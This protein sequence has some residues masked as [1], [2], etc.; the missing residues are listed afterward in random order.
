[1]SAAGEQRAGVDRLDLVEIRVGAR[2]QA[3]PGRAAVGRAEQRPEVAGRVALRA[4]ERHRADR[5]ALR[6]RVAPLPAGRSDL[7]VC[8]RSRPRRPPPRQL[9]PPPPPPPPARASR[10]PPPPRRPRS[11]LP[12]RRCKRQ[13]TNPPVR[14]GAAHGGGGALRGASHDKRKSTRQKPNHFS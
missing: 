2:K 4:R 7:Y 14:R 5:V 12:P 3:G 6:E 9:P 8:A 13:R 11:P 1:A 10:P